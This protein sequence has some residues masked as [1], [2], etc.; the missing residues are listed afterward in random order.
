MPFP[1]KSLATLTNVGVAVVGGREI[2]LHDRRCLADS[3]TL[4]RCHSNF[5]TSIRSSVLTTSVRSSVLTTTWES[6]SLDNDMGGFRRKVEVKQRVDLV[7]C[8][9]TNLL[10][11]WFIHGSAAQVLFVNQWLIHQGIFIPLYLIHYL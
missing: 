5:V 11:N 10:V 3:R 8:P 7:D 6:S 4:S 9:E 2:R 1:P